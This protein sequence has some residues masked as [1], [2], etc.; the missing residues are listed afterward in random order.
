MLIYYALVNKSVPQL[1]KKKSLWESFN[2]LTSPRDTT[3]TFFLAVS[4][5]LSLYY[6]T[7]QLI[8]DLLL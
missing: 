3:Q 6:E 7:K 5:A 4:V 1:K 8:I 2:I